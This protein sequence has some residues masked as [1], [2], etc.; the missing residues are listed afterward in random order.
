MADIAASQAQAV[1]HKRGVD[2]KRIEDLENQL[3][4]LN[5]FC[6]Y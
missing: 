4:D 2:H 6:A 1:S 3:I 5:V